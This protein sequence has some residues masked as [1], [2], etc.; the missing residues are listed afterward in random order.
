MRRRF[1]TV[2]ASRNSSLTLLMPPQPHAIQLNDA[3]EMGEQDL[4]LLYLC[5]GSA[6]LRDSGISSRDIPWDLVPTTDDFAHGG[7]RPASGFQRTYR[8]VALVRTIVNV[9]GFG[10]DA[11]FAKPA[12][13]TAQC[14]TGWAALLIGMFAPLE[15]A[16][17]EGAVVELGFVAHGHMQSDALG[18]NQPAEHRRDTL[19]RIPDQPLRLE[20]KAC[21]DA[22]D[23]ASGAGNFRRPIGSFR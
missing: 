17:G 12:L 14:L 1:W 10:A 16:A 4:G 6:M 23:H 8:T 19:G 11:H 2:A 18:L 7:V 15:V 13:P 20:R 9:V 22:I 3:F 5:A 21:L